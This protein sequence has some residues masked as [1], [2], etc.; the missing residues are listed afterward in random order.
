[1]DRSQRRGG[2]AYR[3]AAW[4]PGSEIAF[5]RFDNWKSGPKPAFKRLVA[6]QVESA[7]SRRA[8]LE[9]GDADLSFNLPP[10]DFSELVAEGKLWVIG[11]P[12]VPFGR[13]ACGRARMRRRS[14]HAGAWRS[15]A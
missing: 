13:A 10:K 11:T 2:D 15:A 1:M 7:G 12:V 3:V 8:L 5:E 6:R 9:K 14:D 4:H